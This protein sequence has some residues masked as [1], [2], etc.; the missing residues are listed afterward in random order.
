[1]DRTFNLDLAT[2][3]A[4]LEFF[5]QRYV[6]GLFLHFEMIP[7]RFPGQKLRDLIAAFPAGSLQFEVGVQTFNPDAAALISRRQD[8]AQVEQNLSWLRRDTGVHL[9]ADLI[10][11]L[12]GEDASS[13]AAG[14]DRLLALGPQEIQVGMLKRLHGAPIS[15]HD[16]LWGMVYSP[17]PPYEVL[18][19]RLIDFPTMQRLRRFARYWDLSGNSGRFRHALPLLWQPD[20]T[21][22]ADCSPFAAFMELSDW[23]FNCVGRTH[24]IA[25]PRLAGLLETYL[26]QAGR[27]SQVVAGALA[28]DTRATAT[29]GPRRQARHAASQEPLPTSGQDK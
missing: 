1:V 6:A 23:L 9:H 20:P 10:V 11:G 27:P 7:D 3:A 4:I 25:L 16:Q 29:C 8:N 17:Q 28:Q 12:P 26:L 5:R 15:R 21:G 18:Q 22:P 24:A 13:F 19:T 2:T 14:F